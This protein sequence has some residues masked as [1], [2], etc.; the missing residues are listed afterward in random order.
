MS[1]SRLEPLS[2]EISA[3][4]S[5]DWVAVDL[6]LCRR[7]GTQWVSLSA[8]C[9]GARSCF[10]WFQHIIGLIWTVK[11]L[12]KLFIPAF[13]WCS[14]IERAALSGMTAPHIPNRVTTKLR[15]FQGRKIDRCIQNAEISY[16]V[17][18]MDYIRLI[19]TVSVSTYSRYLAAWHKYPLESANA[20]FSRY[21]RG[22]KH[23]N[24]STQTNTS[25]KTIQTLQLSNSRAIQKVRHPHT[26]SP[27]YPF[28]R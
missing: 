19:A 15:R 6:A 9:E 27:R 12:F 1:W 4:V 13:L 23:S 17:A 26:F 16:L 8:R 7:D 11:K 21:R 18:I 14:E 22:N 5:T 24:K 20:G 2:K 10:Y 25:T 28:E 3:C